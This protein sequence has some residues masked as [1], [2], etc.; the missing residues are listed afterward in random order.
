MRVE[1][2]VFLIYYIYGLL[3]TAFLWIINPPPF[4]NSPF[5]LMGW[6]IAP[7]IAPI[8]ALIVYPYITIPCLGAA[9]TLLAYYYYR[10]EKRRGVENVV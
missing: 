1:V 9:Y 5:V 4:A 6:L 10:K 8:A 3:V 2:Y 7:F